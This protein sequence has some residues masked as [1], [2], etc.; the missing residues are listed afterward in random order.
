MTLTVLADRETLP[1]EPRRGN[2]LSASCWTLA[3]VLDQSAVTQ[4]P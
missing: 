3:R 4:S 2:I 1:A